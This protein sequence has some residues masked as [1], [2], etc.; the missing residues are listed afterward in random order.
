MPLKELILLCCLD[1]CGCT[2]LAGD[3]VAVGSPSWLKLNSESTRLSN[4][5]F[6]YMNQTVWLKN[7]GDHKV[8]SARIRWRIPWLGTSVVTYP[9]SQCDT[10][11]HM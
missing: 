4:L 5:M 9:D 8:Y 6:L 3:D 2:G 10:M 1:V 11:C 7:F